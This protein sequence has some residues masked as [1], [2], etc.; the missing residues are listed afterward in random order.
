MRGKIFLSLIIGAILGG[1]AMVVCLLVAPDIA[2]WCAL[3]VLAVSAIAM[4]IILSITELRMDKQFAKIEQMLQSPVLYKTIANINLGFGE[5]NG[6]VYLCRDGI[7]LASVDRTPYAV[8]HIP[9]GELARY[10]QDDIYLHLYTK[11]GRE[12]RL[13]LPDAPEVVSVIKSNYW[14]G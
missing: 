11:G 14:N 3:L 4:H 2:L 13:V 10:E 5:V 12:Y 6:R 9:S 8:Q 7:V 1:I